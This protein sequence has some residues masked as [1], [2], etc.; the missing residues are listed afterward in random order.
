MQLREAAEE[1]LVLKRFF[2][3]RFGSSATKRET[4]I[5][6][7][8]QTNIDSVTKMWKG[9]REK[10]DATFGLGDISPSS[11]LSQAF[12]KKPFQDPIL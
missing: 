2:D 1:Q 6:I 10:D 7:D 9:R 12:F 4:R 3:L 8:A 11:N 5:V